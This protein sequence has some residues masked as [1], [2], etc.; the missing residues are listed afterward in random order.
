[1]GRTDRSAPFFLRPP[2]PGFRLRPL[3][4]LD[5]L[6]AAW[7]DEPRDHRGALV[8]I[9]ILGVLLRL[10]HLG[11]PM[12]YDESVTF[13]YFARLPWREAVATYTYPNNHI[14]HTLAL[15]AA[16]SLFGNSPAVIRL[17]AF[18]A[19][20]LLIPASYAVARELYG[21]RVALLAS[22]LVAASGALVLYST[23]ARGYTM[24]VLAFLLLVLVGARLLRGAPARE[25]LTFAMIGALGL[26]TIPTMLYPLGAVA[27][28]LALSFAV[29]TPPRSA[30]I[31]R[32]AIALAVCGL[33]TALMYAPVVAHE[34][35]SAITRNKFVASSGW[36]QF[37]S[38]LPTSLSEAVKS[39]ALG[40]P[41]AISILLAVGVLIALARHTALSCCRVGLPLA[42]FVWCAWLLAVNH[43]APFARIWIWCVPIVACLAAAGGLSL[44]DSRPRLRRFVAERFVALAVGLTLAASTSVA[45]SRAVF[46]TLDTGTY[47]D[48]SAAVDVLRRS[49]QP[50]DRVVLAIPTNA[51]LAYYLD[52][53]GVPVSLVIRDER[54]AGR[55]IA[56]VNDAEHQ[57]LAGVIARSIARDSTQFVG[58]RVLARLPT[59]TLFVFTRRDSSTH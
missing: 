25:W 32:L 21:G 44:A 29:E 30:E 20:I 42:M 58:P 22:A 47:R 19:G 4:L 43:R 8:F 59:S 52:R 1:M 35:L 33:L 45:L 31:R 50:T 54:T 38:D 9:T 39:W 5:E 57:T 53:A 27:L 17:P 37:L 6:R 15:K 41:P 56:I 16:V 10:L 46:L 14:L 24:V 48:A 55:I 34:G 49:S 2:H 51:P 28:W 7:R 36:F 23:N 40:V 18:A 13:L 26:W 12:R 11:Q 3:L